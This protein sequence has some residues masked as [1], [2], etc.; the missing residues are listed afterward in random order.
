MRP[1]NLY[2]HLSKAIL[3]IFIALSTRS[4]FAEG[5]PEPSVVL[6]GTIRNVAV[7]NVRVTS[8]TLVWQFRE[9][10]S[11]WTA[12][13]TCQVTNILD[14]FSYVLEIP[15]EQVISANL[16][17][18]A[19]NLTGT[20][21]S[22]DCSVVTCDGAAATFADASQTGVVLSTRDR[23]RMI[24]VDLLVSAPCTDLDKNGLC[25]DWEMQHFGYIG[26]APNDD[27]DHD[28]MSNLLE[29]RAGTDPL[30]ATSVFQFLSVEHL[31]GKTAR[32]GW[33][34]ADG[35]YYTLLRYPSLTSTNATVVQTRILATTPRTS[36]VDTNAPPSGMCF[37][38]L[39][40]EP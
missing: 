32:V 7:Q 1:P 17:S 18:T 14:Q 16:S 2:S 27:S 12:A 3:C 31:G 10:A 30:D 23:G 5:I 29:F 6:Y 40:L 22:F 24:R 21:K 15:C 9:T 4:S 38:R 20:P 33:Q 26:V 37:Y 25:D 13:F 11:G 8:G 28:G 36:W 35:R 34:S 39:I 19:L